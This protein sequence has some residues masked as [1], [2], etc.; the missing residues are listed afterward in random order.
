MKP[1]PEQIQAAVMSSFKN[2]HLAIGTAITAGAMV[3]KPCA[4]GTK[5]WTI[6]VEGTYYR[7]D[8]A[9]PGA[10]N[11]FIEAEPERQEKLRRIL[12]GTNRLLEE[13]EDTAALMRRTVAENEALREILSPLKMSAMVV[14]RDE[15][16]DI[17]STVK[18]EKDV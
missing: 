15:K 11:A 8:E 2:L 6:S 9:K 1:T 14:K 18:F 12:V 3:I 4:A 5:G 13:R 16:G 7:L 10:L 17:A